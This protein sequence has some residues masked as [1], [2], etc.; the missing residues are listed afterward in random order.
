VGA[1]KTEEGGVIMARPRKPYRICKHRRVNKKGEIKESIRWNIYFRDHLQTERKVTGTPDK[2]T[3]EYLA[4]HII[5][6]VNFRMTKQPLNKE[7]RDFIDNQPKLRKKLFE[8]NIIDA[9]TNSGFE[10]LAEY[11]EVKAKNSK[12]NTYKVTG[13]HLL[14]WQQSMIDRGYSKQHIKE[15][16]ARVIRLIEACG[17]F[18]PSDIDRTKLQS[19]LSKINES[20]GA[21]VANGMLK[22]FNVFTRWMLRNRR[23]SSNPVQYIQPFKKSEPEKERERRPLSLSEIKRLLSATEASDTHHGMT[24]RERTLVYRIAMSTGLRYNEIRTLKRSNFSVSGNQ[25]SVSIKRGNAKNRKSDTLPLKVEL[26]ADLKQYFDNKPALPQARAFKMWKDAGA[27]ML[28]PDLE[29]AGIQYIVDGAVADFHS[30]RHT[31]ATLLAQAGVSLQEAQRLMRHCDPKLTAS[32]YTHLQL[33][34]TAKAVGKIPS[35][36]PEQAKQ[37]KTGTFDAQENLIV[38]LTE[39]P[40]K[41]QRNRAESSRAKICNAKDEKAIKPCKTNHLTTESEMRVLGLEPKTYGLKGHIT[42]HKYLS[43]QYL[44]AFFYVKKH[45]TTI[46]E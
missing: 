25:P 14:D 24:G 37:V 3:T 16:I 22:S 26:A 6:I 30:L 18:A 20:K 13:G 5:S 41:S 36:R 1:A 32:I 23:M 45:Y 44:Y 12:L 2:S 33:H 8:W 39:N 31:F 38:N 15:S 35:L 46:A 9:D 21:G 43:S 42:A 4:R 10:P 34:D 40:T 28:K 17:F 27:A 19:G 29:A 11:D 7:I